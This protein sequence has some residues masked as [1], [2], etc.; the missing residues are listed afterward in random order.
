VTFDVFV[1]Y[2]S[3]DKPSADAACA[4]L[5]SVGIRCW[6]APRDILPGA[7]YGEAIIDAI[8]GAKVFVLIFSGSANASPQIKRE[9]ERAVSKSIPIIPVRIE[10][11]LPNKS[12]EY[13]ISTPHWLDAFTPPLEAHLKQLAASVQ[14]LLKAENTPI[15]PPGGPPSLSD[16]RRQFLTA[17]TMW[18]LERAEYVINAFIDRSPGNVEALQLRRQIGTAMER[19]RQ[20]TE[21]RA[22]AEPE[23]QATAPRAAGRSESFLRRRSTAATAA[24]LAALILILIGFVFWQ[25]MSHRDPLVRTLVGH[26]KE[27]DSVA[28]SPDGKQIA[29]GGWDGSIQI[30]N[31]ADGTTIRVLGGY[32]GRSALYSPDGKWIACGGDKTF[33][34]WDATTGYP[35]LTVPGFSKKVLTVAFTPDGNSIVSGGRDKTVQVW[36]RADG[37]LLLTLSGHTEAVWAVEVSPSGKDIVSAGDDGTIR[38]WNAATGAPLQKIAGNAGNVHAATFSPDG[39]QIASGMQDGTVRLWHTDSG[40]PVKQ[41]PGHLGA[42]M[43][44]AYSPDGKLIASAGYDGAVIIWNTDTGQKVTTLKGHVGPVYAVTFSPDGKLIASAGDDKLVKIWNAP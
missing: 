27:A 37:K 11:V 16:I 40:Q 5:E 35:A 38:V 7:D 24:G 26:T 42:V 30:W 43:S 6:I 13:F 31:V 21:P 12:L 36:T 29:S 1:S 9:V 3:H 25:H 39:A 32:D 22:A 34:V 18:D 2:S 19:E 23:R 4:T 14:T 10:N 8:E 33:K 15:P 41:L 44:V 17:N 20:M 28:F